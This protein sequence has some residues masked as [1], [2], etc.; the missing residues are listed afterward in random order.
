[1]RDCPQ[2]GAAVAP[3]A[4]QCPCCGCGEHCTAQVDHLPLP[5]ADARFA[6]VPLLIAALVAG[7]AVLVAVVSPWASGAAAVEQTTDPRSGP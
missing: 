3:G 6:P 7:L 2:C 5:D 1:M 4:P